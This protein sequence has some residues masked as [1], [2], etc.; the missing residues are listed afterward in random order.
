MAQRLND[1][2]HCP[3][4]LQDGIAP[5]PHAALSAEGLVGIARHVHIVRPHVEEEGGVLPRVDEADR[6]GRQRVGDM[7]VLPKGPAASFHVADARD[8]IDD[9]LIVAVVGRRLQLGEHLRMILAQ[10]FALEGL[11]IVDVDRRRGVVVGHALV[12][13][14]H[15]GHPVGRRRHQ[16]GVVETEIARTGSHLGVPIL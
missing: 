11:V 5:K 13:H 15:T 7:L 14:P 4:E 6:L 9:G 16:V 2:S 10:R 8:A 1:L 3:V 12:V